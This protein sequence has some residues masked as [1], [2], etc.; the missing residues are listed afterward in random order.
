MKRLGMFAR[1]WEPGRVK[2]RLIS[3][4]GVSAA[5]D[6]HR[7][8]VQTL[9]WRFRAV[10]DVRTICVTPSNRV[11]GLREAIPREWSVEPQADGD[12]GRRL[13][14][15]FSPRVAGGTDPIVVIGSDSPTLPLASIERAFR[16]LQDN[17]VVLGPADDGGYYLIGLRG[18]VPPLFDDLPWGTDRVLEITRRRLDEVGIAYAL[19]EPWYD[20]DRPADLDRLS[21]DVAAMP[22][23]DPVWQPLREFADRWR[24]GEWAGFRKPAPPI[25]S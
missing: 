24:E 17:P 16:E 1:Y 12:L 2:T 11:D 13:H 10:G 15:F 7:R 21:R 6:L 9:A 18:L 8:S 4:L 5:A 25:E 3:E 19:L 14:A 20:V 22:G 23:D